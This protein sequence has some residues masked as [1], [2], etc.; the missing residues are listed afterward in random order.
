MEPVIYRGEKLPGWVLGLREGDKAILV[1]AAQAFPQYLDELE[2]EPTQY[3]LTVARRCITNDL[4]ALVGPGI[5]V[6]FSEPGKKGNDREWR[7]DNFPEG[8]KPGEDEIS[9]A[10][11]FDNHWKHLK[12]KRL[13]AKAALE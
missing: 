3:S 8:S 9:G 1:D 11:D 2:M 7:L 6:N 10:R 12:E 13:Q 4:K 5:I